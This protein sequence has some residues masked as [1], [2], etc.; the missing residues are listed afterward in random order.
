MLLCNNLMGL[1]NCFKSI[2]KLFFLILANLPQRTSTCML[3]A[4]ERR[5]S[6]LT[7]IWCFQHILDLFYLCSQILLGAQ[8]L[9]I[10]FSYKFQPCNLLQVRLCRIKTRV[11]GTS[12]Y[13]AMFVVL[14][15]FVPMRSNEL[16]CF[17]LCSW[18]LWKALEEE[19]EGCI[20]FGSM[21]FGLAVQK[22]LNI[23]FFFTEN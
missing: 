2:G 14:F 21:L 13:E 16:G 20:G 7:R 17:R 9:T 6:F 1:C 22:F 5:I 12:I 11:S 15:C 19:E 18:S 8:T 10:N 23:E 4:R 3:Q